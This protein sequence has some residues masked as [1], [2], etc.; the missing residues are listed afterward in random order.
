MRKLVR[1]RIP[2]ILLSWESIT[3]DVSEVTDDAE[4]L[5][6]LRAKLSE[7]VQEFLDDESPEELADVLEVVYALAGVLGMSAA[8]LDALREDKA[9]ER[10]RFEKRFVWNGS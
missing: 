5:E 7:E 10:G 1:D 4:F 8:R 2:E 6:W 3:I 9:Q